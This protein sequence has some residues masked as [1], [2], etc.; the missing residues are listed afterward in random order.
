MNKS[1]T[2]AFVQ[3]MAWLMLVCMMIGGHCMAETFM[4]DEYS[5]DFDF[6]E[7]YRFP[8]SHIGE[9][10][11]ICGELH[12]SS[13]EHEIGGGYSGVWIDLDEYTGQD[14]YIIL[15]ID[16]LEFN[17]LENDWAEVYLTITGTG[18]LGKYF[19]NH[20]VFYAHA[21]AI[22]IYDQKEGEIVASSI[23]E[24][25]LE[26]IEQSNAESRFTKEDLSVDYLLGSW[27]TDYEEAFGMKMFPDEYGPM[28]DV[29]FE[30]GNIC[31]IA[32]SGYDYTTEWTLEN[33]EIH[34]EALDYDI[35]VNPD[36]TLSFTHDTS[37]F[38]LSKDD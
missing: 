32:L 34:I 11:V 19:E 1:Q 24:D 16:P 12:I 28:L 37:T 15:E 6:R 10:Y 23:D 17:L 35:S 20:E 30:E 26:K 27:T 9:K 36:G 38:V 18:P 21:D 33:G 7:T 4:V 3:M 13:A 31:K 25:T 5:R 22:T 14:E 8:D 29:A 2:K